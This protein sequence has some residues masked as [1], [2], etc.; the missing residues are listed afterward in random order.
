[1]RAA[2]AMLAVCGF[3]ASISTCAIF[4]QAEDSDPATAESLKAV[5]TSSPA[6]S[7]DD[8]ETTDALDSS[9]T[10]PDSGKQDRSEVEQIAEPKNPKPDFNIPGRA[11]ASADENTVH[12][13]TFDD[14]VFE[15]E[16]GE[17]FLRS[18][19]T[20]E[21][22]QY[23]GKKIRLRGYIRPSFSQSGLTKFVFV[24]DNKECCFGPGAALYD[25]VLVRLADGE[26]TNYTVRPVTI[27]GLFYLKEYT[28]P[29]GNVWSIFR[30]KDGRVR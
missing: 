27:E 21:V 16:K 25:C 11:V 5:E 9:P 4:A 17:K 29:D 30:M 10:S 23:H 6:S 13:L 14:L 26:S 18:M 12:D 8:P 28:G 15:M 22:I 20:P 19:L 7:P 3:M 1:M 2:I 24:R